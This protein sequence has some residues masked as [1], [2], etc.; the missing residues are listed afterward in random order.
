[1]FEP[2]IDTIEKY[3]SIVIF[4]HINPDGDCYGSAV[5]LK[6]IFSLKY[7][8]K[9]F[10]ITGSGLPRFFEVLMPMDDVS[11]EII[12]NS[13]ALLV[14]ANDLMRMEDQRIHNCKAFVKID[15][16]VDTGSF[17]EGPSVVDEDANSTCDMIVQMIAEQNLP[18]DSLVANALYFCIV[19]V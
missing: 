7:P 6:R 15:H 3:D 18:I 8:E 19:S 1:M 9:H 4:G 11:D 14:D 10:Y 13:L 12:S 5:A 17:T 16:H 2:I